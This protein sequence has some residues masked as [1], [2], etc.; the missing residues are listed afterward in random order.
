MGLF[1]GGQFEDD[2][3]AAY[4]WAGLL[5]IGLYALYSFVKGESEDSEDEVE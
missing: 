5:C 3:E 1:N 4:T 2:T